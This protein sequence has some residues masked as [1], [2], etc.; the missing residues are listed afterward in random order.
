MVRRYLSVVLL[1]VL[2]ACSG[3]S[4]PPPPVF[5][6]PVYTP[7][8]P[9]L[10]AGNTISVNASER[11]F[12]Y[13]VPLDL[14]ENAPLLIVFHGGGQNRSSVI[15]GTGGATGWVDVADD[16]GVLLIL[17]NGTDNLGNADASAAFWND[18]RVDRTGGSVAD[19]TAFLN[20]LID[21]ALLNDN[22][23][24]DAERVYV[25]GASNG[26][27]MGFRAALEAGDRLAGVAT[28]IAN[29]AALPDELCLAAENET[30]PEP[31]SMLIWLGTE[32]L[33]M[34]F[35]GGEVG[36]G[37]RGTVLSALETVNFWIARNQTTETEPVMAYPDLD[38]TDG[39]T[40]VGE[41]YVGGADDSE[42][43]FVTVI[44]GGHSMPSLR[45][46]S[47]GRQNRDV[48][49]AVEAWAFLSTQT[50]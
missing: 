29:Q 11:V 26:G 15:D 1:P 34:P 47:A 46:P 12:D 32:D 3:S 33:L 27:L 30:A 14:P 6:P 9:G 20:G 38:P 19:D 16:N 43:M 18:C 35:D 42:V 50:R 44:G 2:A 31:V 36:L 7:P 21:W 22:F 40:V 45:Y 10:F 5:D 28:F 4:S 24:V 48:E 49:S 39:S 8:T 25:A 17:P 23:L 41:R 37:D 13:Y